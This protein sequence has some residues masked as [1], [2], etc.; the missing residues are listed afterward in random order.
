M[1][2]NEDEHSFASNLAQ[3]ISIQTGGG[4]QVGDR[5]G[6]QARIKSAV[7]HEEGIAAVLLLE[8]GAN[9]AKKG[10]LQLLQRQRLVE[11]E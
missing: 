2:L 10:H 5:D 3:E 1:Q 8:E 4:G 9:T 7:L 6:N 11:G